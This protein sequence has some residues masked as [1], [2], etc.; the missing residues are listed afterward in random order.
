MKEL[1]AGEN[2][3]IPSAEITVSVT[4]GCTLDVSA[5][6]LGSDRRV[7]S[8]ADL[9]FFNNPAGPGVTFLG[10]APGGLT[11]VRIDTVDVPADVETVILTASLDGT[12]PATFAGAGHTVVTVHDGTG[13]EAVR[14]AVDG[15]S[16]ETALVC[17]EVYRRAGVW[18]VRAVGQG[19]DAGLAGIATDFG[20][21]ITDDESEPELEPAR[22]TPDSAATGEPRSFQSTPAYGGHPMNSDLFA[23]VHAEVA[24][25]GMQKQGA[26]MCKVALDG[27]VMA[28]SGSMVAYQGNLQFS[29]LG[30]GGIGNVIKQKLTGEGVPLMKVTGRGDLFLANNAGD[31][32]L[33]DL[34]GNDGLTI[35]G[36]NVLAFES[37]LQYKIERVHGAA[38]VSGAGLFN[39]VFTGRGRLAMTTKGAP[40]VLTVDEATYADPQAAVAWSASLRTGVQSNDQFNLGTL[41]GRSTGERF[42]LS[43]SGQGFVVVQPSEEPPGGIIGGTGKGEQAGVGG[44]LGGLLGR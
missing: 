33:V 20:I 18:K 38:M 43:F 35:N 5:V 29:A 11:A 36:A 23:P 12:G 8:D 31:V 32:H 22:P 34:D 14:F 28:R 1:S 30:S 13:V 6:L 15:L 39:C 19:Y 3:A 17:L 2:C 27:E 16:T 41:I 26:K 44:T 42:T 37:T 40:V 9:I 25:P 7:R 10:Q 21:D 24:G 4:C